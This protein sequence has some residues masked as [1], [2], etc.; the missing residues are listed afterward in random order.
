MKTCESTSEI[1]MIQAKIRRKWKFLPSLLLCLDLLQPAG[2]AQPHKDRIVV[3]I[4]LDGFPAYALDD[5]R[6]P[7]PTLRKLAREGSYATSMQPINPTVTW[8][9]HTAMVTGVDASVHHVLFNG[10][11]V[12]SSPSDQP[13]IEPQRDKDAMVH[14]PTVYDLAF[15]AGLTTAQVDWVAIHN[16]KTITWQFPELPDPKGLV[17]QEM[18]ADGWVTSE[19]L[20]SYEEGSQAWQDEIWTDAAI[21]ILKEHKPNLLLFHLLSLDN[22]SHEYGPMSSASF[23]AMAFLDDRVKQIIDALHSADLLSRTTVLIVSDHGFRKVDHAIHPAELLREADASKS[24]QNNTGVRLADSLS[25]MPEG[26]TASVYIND[27]RNKKMLTQTINALFKNAEGIDHVY[28]SDEFSRLGW[29]I[30]SQ[31]DQAP[32]VLLTAKPGYYFSSEPSN[33]FVTNSREKGSHGYLNTDSEMQSIFIAWGAGIQSGKN[34]GSIS[35]LDVAPTIASLL[36]LTMENVSGH[37][38]EPLVK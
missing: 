23:M 30:V 7:I 2:L 38:I 29:P 11:L 31:S 8:P 15:Q 22:E 20:L 26:G 17:E 6:L 33:I 9:N 21:R 37:A 32:D 18:I 16:A 1:L 34:L 14:A 36:G 12:R 24:R 10:L 35:N 25:V 5:P 3:V 28:N 13:T 4:S 19:Q 27:A